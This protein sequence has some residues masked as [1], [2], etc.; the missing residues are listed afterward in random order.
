MLAGLIKFWPV[1]IPVSLYFLWLQYARWQ[2]RKKGLPITRFTEG[3]WVW[4]I[5]S[6]LIIGIACLILWRLEAAPEKGD[7]SPPQL[8]DG[9]IVPGHIEQP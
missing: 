1:L 7:Y 3:P 2:A 5:V 8:R 9:Q 4:M 6:S